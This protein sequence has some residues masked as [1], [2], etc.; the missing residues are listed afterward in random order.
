[1]CCS[2]CL[3]FGRMNAELPDMQ[4]NAVIFLRLLSVAAVFSDCPRSTFSLLAFLVYK[5]ALKME[6]AQE[7]KE[8]HV[9]TLIIALFHSYTETWTCKSFLMSAFCGCVH[10]DP[11]KQQIEM[12]RG[13][14]VSNSQCQT[15]WCILEIL[16]TVF[17]HV[18]LR[19]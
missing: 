7:G 9:G 2:G 16:V 6:A 18:H 12:I 4:R 19:R 11:G 17:V 14:G 8:K 15:M 1:M 3:C 10:N 13:S 5:Y